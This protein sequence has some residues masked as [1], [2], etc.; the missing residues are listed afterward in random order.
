MI[1]FQFD[2]STKSVVVGPKLFRK[3]GVPTVPEKLELGKG[4]YNAFPFMR[5]ALEKE[6][7]NFPKLFTNA[8][9]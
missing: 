1:F 6:A 9:K 8:V 5:P 7:V 3:T 4:G 2:P